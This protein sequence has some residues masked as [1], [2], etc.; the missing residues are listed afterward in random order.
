MIVGETGKGFNFFGLVHRSHLSALR[1]RNDPSLH[2][3]LV[4]DAVIGMADRIDGDLAVLVRTEG[5]TCI[6][7]VF[8]GRRIRPYRCAR[9][10]C[11]GPHG[12]GGS[13]PAGRAHWLQFR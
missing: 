10:R 3:M 2:V 11:I 4:T 1:D 5:S 7:Y 13:T 12:R 6:R 8:P 9:S